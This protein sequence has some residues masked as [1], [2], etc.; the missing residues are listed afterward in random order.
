MSIK[1]IVTAVLLAGALTGCAAQTPPNGMGAMKMDSGMCQK[2]MSGKKCSCCQMMQNMDSMRTSGM[3]TGGM[4]MNCQPVGGAQKMS[5]PAKKSAEKAP[6]KPVE[7]AV[8]P[9]EHK[10]HHPAQ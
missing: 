10:K 9:E 5:T 3:M 2:M 1:K 7:S 6:P 4:M 8:D